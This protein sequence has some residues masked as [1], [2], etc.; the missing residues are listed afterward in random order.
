M[1]GALGLDE[2][3]KE[4]RKGS[5]GADMEQYEGASKKMKRRLKMAQKM[6]EKNKVSTVKKY[7]LVQPDPNWP[8]VEK[9]LTMEKVRMDKKT[10][11]PVF[12]YIKTPEYV[13]LQKE[14]EAV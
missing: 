14:F 10:G 12:S 7:L 1:H 11:Q 3:D 6:F 8:K 4:E 2:E 9:I 13:S 5:R